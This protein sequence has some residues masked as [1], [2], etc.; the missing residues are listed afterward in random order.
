MRAL[1]AAA[2]LLA[3]ASAA[4]RTRPHERVLYQW[5]DAEGN[6]RYTTAPDEVPRHA[7]DT[8][9][10]VV[11]G[12]SAEQNAALLPGARTVPRPEPS[13]R[14]WLRGE[15]TDAGAAAS[16]AEVAEE[17]RVPT[18]PEEIAALDARIR[19]LEQQITEAEVDLANQLGDDPGAQGEAAVPEAEQAA[20]VDPAVRAAA[21]HLDG[22]RAE[23]EALRTERGLVAPANGP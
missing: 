8:L 15:E 9:A 16:A 4:C 22:L 10:K 3:L 6:V 7:R 12:H 13:A 2:L 5:A 1:A 11:P 17:A 18:T 14:E 23:L 19:A 21:D 20:E